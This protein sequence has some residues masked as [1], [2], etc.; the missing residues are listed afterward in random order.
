[1]CQ[2]FIFSFSSFYINILFFF[3]TWSLVSSRWTWWVCREDC[4]K[5]SLTRIRRICWQGEWQWS[6]QYLICF[7]FLGK[8]ILHQIYAFILPFSESYRDEDSKRCLEK[9]RHVVQ[10]RGPVIHGWLWMDVL[11]GQIGRYIPL[12]RW[13]RFHKWGRGCD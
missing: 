4:K 9:R 11:C 7:N 12:E 2:Q 1:M 5:P 3:R 8:S 6:R 10:V 13:K